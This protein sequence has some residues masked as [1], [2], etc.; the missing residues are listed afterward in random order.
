V[1]TK[2]AGE[3]HCITYSAWTSSCTSK[4]WGGVTYSL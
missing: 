1:I 2:D 3:K 4:A